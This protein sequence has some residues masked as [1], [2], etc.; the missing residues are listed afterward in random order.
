MHGRPGRGPQPARRHSPHAGTRP[1][2][3][4]AGT[5][6]RPPPPHGHPL[7][8]GAVP[9]W[10]LLRPVR[11]LLQRPPEGGPAARPGAAYPLATR[12]RTGT[13]P[14]MHTLIVLVL[15]TEI[16]GTLRAG[17]DGVAA[18]TPLLNVAARA[19]DP[20]HR[21]PSRRTRRRRSA[22]WGDQRPCPKG[23]PVTIRPGSVATELGPVPAWPWPG[24]F[25]RSCGKS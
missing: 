11:R 12:F 3:R 19:A 24:G 15:L 13:P 22:R 5:A 25:T 10:P 2:L 7:V 23:C 6:A 16:S 21:S 18:A 8:A 1:R 14:V 20:G 17:V 4:S 9:A